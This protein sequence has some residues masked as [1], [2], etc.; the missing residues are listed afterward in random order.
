MDR[1]GS[2]MANRAKYKKHSSAASEEAPWG[3]FTEGGGLAADRWLSNYEMV[4][5]SAKQGKDLVKGIRSTR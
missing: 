1:T 4:M 2:H 3:Y 5:W